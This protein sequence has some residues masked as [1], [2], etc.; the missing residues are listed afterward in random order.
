VL[1]PQQCTHGL[2]ATLVSV[3]VPQPHASYQQRAI[4]PSSGSDGDGCSVGAQLHG[5][6]IVPHLC[7]HTQHPRCQ[8]ITPA[9]CSNANACSNAPPPPTKLTV[10][11][12]AAVVCVALTKVSVDLVVPPALDAP[13]VLHKHLSVTASMSTP[14]AR[15][16]PRE[17]CI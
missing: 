6:K 14:Q 10:G 5:R 4:V 7:T 8:N 12:I 15:E 9:R 1:P 13:V 16:L 3:V 11:V 2:P 17:G